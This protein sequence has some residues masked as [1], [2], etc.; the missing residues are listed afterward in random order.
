M[1]PIKVAL[2][3][4]DHPRH[5]DSRMVGIWSY[6]VPEFEVTRFPQEKYVDLSRLQFQEF[7]VIFQEDARLQVTWNDKGDTPLI[8]YVVDSTLSANHYRERRVAAEQFLCA[9]KSALGMTGI[10]WNGSRG[11]H[12]CGG[13][14]IASM[15]KCSPRNTATTQP[16]LVSFAT[17]L[18]N[19]GD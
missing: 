10:N 8:Y 12:L 5:I 17:I 15:I 18:Q 4:A 1:N 6:P 3:H 9:T 19:G 2:V 16:T 14:R 13:C 7:D 11:A